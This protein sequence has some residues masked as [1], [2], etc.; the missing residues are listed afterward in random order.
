MSKKIIYFVHCYPPALGGLEYLSGEIVKIL[1]EAGHDVQVIT[2]RGQTL[3]SYKTF[4]NW[5][6]TINDPKYIHRLSLN[7]FWQ[8]I[9]NK[10]LN[11]LIFISGSF[12]PWYFGPILKYDNQILNL[13]KEAD[14]I[15]GAGMPTKLFYD[16]YRFANKYN[17]KLILH[18]SF[19]DVSYYKN[20]IFFQ[21]ALIFAYKI[22]YQTP[23]EKNNL[24]KSYKITKNKLVQLTYCPYT[25]NDWQKAIKRAQIKE[26]ELQDKLKKKLPIT[27]GYIGQITLRKNFQFFVNF[28]KE[29]QKHFDEKEIKIN[30]LFAGAKTNSS[31]QVETL[32]KE[33]KDVVKFIYNFKEK[34][35]EKIFKYIDIFVNP[36]V[37]ESLGLVNFEAMYWGLHC[38]VSSDSAFNSLF[39]V[40]IDRDNKYLIFDFLDL[41]KIKINNLIYIFSL[42]AY[43]SQILNLI[44]K[45]RYN[46]NYE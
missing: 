4:S 2:G 33:Y 15:I 25:K 19:H 39:K 29:N 40:D 21:K 6:D 45:F 44:G 38:F 5:V 31:T 13:I 28:I 37:E 10:L 32:F 17:K 12:S 36:S 14:L 1:R 42:D 34:D 3:D 41:I 18:P 20:S 46:T 9:A 43:R 22:I 35:K 16:A 26:A 27:I 11:K 7:Y 24:K 23:L 8:R 30:F